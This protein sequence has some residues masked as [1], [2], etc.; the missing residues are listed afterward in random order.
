MSN[1]Y[2]T[3]VGGLGNQLFQIA[4]G[5]A[6]AKKYGKNLIL[7]DTRW[8]ISHGSPG[9]CPNEYKKGIFKNFKFSGYHI[10]NSTNI[11]ES[12]F[13]FDELPYIKGDVVL[14]GYFQSDKYFSEYAEEFKSLLNFD[15]YLNIDLKNFGPMHVAAHVRRSDFLQHINVHYVCDTNYFTSTF[16]TFGESVIDIYSDSIPHVMDEFQYIP[17]LRFISG[18]D[19]VRTLYM[20][21]QYDNIIA[22]NSSFSWWAS[23]LGKKKEKILVPDRWFN[24]FENHDDIYRTDFTRIAV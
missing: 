1:V 12:R 5:Y 13:N 15:N 19:D 2:V 23:F 16:P 21:S 8:T 22:S 3:L 7:D 11:S 10:K 18:S 9:K 24:N 20:L 17:N 14:H 4:A 6:Y